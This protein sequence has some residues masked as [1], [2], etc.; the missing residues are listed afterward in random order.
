MRSVKC[1]DGW[2]VCAILTSFAFSLKFKVNGRCS[3]FIFISH[4]LCGV[5][6]RCEVRFIAIVKQLRFAAVVPRS[7]YAWGHPRV[8]ENPNCV[9]LR[10]SSARDLYFWIVRTCCSW[11]VFVWRL[12]VIYSHCT[13]IAQC[14][15]SWQP[16]CSICTEST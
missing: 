7:L 13:F 10:D 3:G 6:T 2:F 1:F 15:F 11:H 12:A 14:T 4:M 5:L 8:A 16:F 9:S